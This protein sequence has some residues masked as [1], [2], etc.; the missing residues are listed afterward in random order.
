MELQ[1]Y[2]KISN[3]NVDQNL[4]LNNNDD[5]LKAKLE[6]RRRRKFIRESTSKKL[7][8]N[9]YQNIV[10]LENIITKDPT[11]ESLFELVNLYKV[12]FSN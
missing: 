5:E 6:R 4:S 12:S 3:I 2:E 9:Y 7:P 11:Q 8:S 1:S 10:E